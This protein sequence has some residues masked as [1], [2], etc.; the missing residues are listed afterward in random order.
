M[1]EVRSDRLLLWSWR[2]V[3]ENDKEGARHDQIV[4]IRDRSRGGGKKEVH[5]C[6]TS[7]F[8]P[9]FHFVVGWIMTVIVNLIYD[10]A[11]INLMLFM[12]L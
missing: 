8:I 4:A 9:T 7:K 5:T 12:P 3:P 1:S 11:P 6:M 10:Y 2:Q